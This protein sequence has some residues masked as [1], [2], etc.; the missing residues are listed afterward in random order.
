MVRD[1]AQLPKQVVPIDK[2]QS[3]IFDAFLKSTFGFFLAAMIEIFL[4]C[5]CYNFSKH[6]E[7]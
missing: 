2:R 7:I 5:V 6:T 1:N 3:P 4:D